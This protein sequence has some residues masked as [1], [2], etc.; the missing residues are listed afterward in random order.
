[1]DVR[2]ITDKRAVVVP[3]ANPISV[4]FLNVYGPDAWV[5]VKGCDGC[6]AINECCGG[7]PMAIPDVGCAVHLRTKSK[8]P[9]FCIKYPEPDE[10]ISYCQQVFK[11]VA[12]KY[13]GKI[14]KVCEPADVFHD[15][16]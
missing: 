7:C 9:F 10:H 12:G 3:V 2:Q 8:K 6:K 13:K 16:T 11:C 5:Q 15:A 1:M 14:R 4:G